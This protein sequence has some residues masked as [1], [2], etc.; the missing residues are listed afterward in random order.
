MAC[1][2]IPKFAKTRK[3]KYCDRLARVANRNPHTL[4]SGSRVGQR[5]THP[6]ALS[7]ATEASVRSCLRAHKAVVTERNSR[8]KACKGISDRALSSEGADIGCGARG[9]GTAGWLAGADARLCMHARSIH[10]R[11]GVLSLL[12]SLLH[13]VCAEAHPANVRSSGTRRMASWRGWEST[14]RPCTARPEPQILQP[15]SSRHAGAAPSNRCGS[16]LQRRCC[17]ERR[18]APTVH[19]RL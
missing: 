19:A 16:V 9:H 5:R 10:R 1:T 11:Q 3:I 15:R 13:H 12:A 17:P 8:L 7:A 14:G 4:A 18:A 2:N 6:G